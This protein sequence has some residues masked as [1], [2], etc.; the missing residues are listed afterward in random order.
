MTVSAG[1]ASSAGRDA[2]GDDRVEEPG[3]V[4]VERHAALVR[5]RRDRARV[6]DGSGRPPEWACVFS[7]TT[8]PVIG[9]WR[10]VGSRNASTIS[11]GSIVPSGRSRQGADRRPDDD[12]VAAGLVQH[13]VGGRPGDGLVAARQVGHQR[14]EVAH[15]AA[16]DEQAGL[17]AQQLGGARLER[18]DRGVVA[19]H[20]VAE[21]GRGHRAAHR[22]GR[23]GDRVG[24]EIDQG[25]GRASIAR[26]ARGGAPDGRPVS[27]RSG[28]GSCRA[29]PRPLA[30]GGAVGG[31]A[32]SSARQRP[33]RV[34]A[35]R[36]RRGRRAEAARLLRR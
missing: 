15:R 35:S 21:L 12:R 18:V 27:P 10:S 22:V 5:D 11:A 28:A 36:G 30:I 9:S 20:V 26:V 17:L 24:A 6:V 4:D 16:R 33:R 23:V 34:P 29:R 7:R 13:G 2:E 19:E 31:L 32:A 25:H 14:D 3:A 8:R 1:P